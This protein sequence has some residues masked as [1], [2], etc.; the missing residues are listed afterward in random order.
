MR[1]TWMAALLGLAVTS[2]LWADL[3]P[4]PRPKPP[5]RERPVQEANIVVVADA[6]A[7]APKLIVPQKIATRRAELDGQSPD[8][9]ASDEQSRPWGQTILAGT[10]LALAVSFTGLWMVRRGR[11][12]GRGT[13]LLIAAGVCLTGSAIVGA[14]AAPPVRPKPPAN[15]EIYSGKIAVE[16]TA[17]GD[18]IKLIV[19]PDMMATMAKGLAN[20]AVG[21]APNAP[22][23]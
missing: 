8:R 4:N 2:Q 3:P 19:P 12:T 5:S 16:Y 21:A 13:A 22:A 11:A 20:G 23:K 6:N 18:T 7:K 14:N 15:Q 9:L 17:E 10:A 1:L